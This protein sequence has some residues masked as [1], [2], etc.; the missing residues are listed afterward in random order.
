MV[1]YSGSDIQKRPSARATTSLMKRPAA[2]AAMK[3]PAAS[4]VVSKPEKPA[5]DLPSAP[6]VPEKKDQTLGEDP[7]E[8]PTEHDPVIEEP[9]GL[10]L[11]A[12]PDSKAEVLKKPSKPDLPETSQDPSNVLRGQVVQTVEKTNGWK[13]V[14]IQTAKGRKYW[15][16]VSADGSYFF[17]K[18]QA[19][20]HGFQD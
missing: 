5:V 17:S 4:P 6:A 11:G 12:T 15:K 7:E 14:Q 1:P 16:W 9:Q 13:K 19:G 2:P 20:A 10:A 8:E 18:V 3:R